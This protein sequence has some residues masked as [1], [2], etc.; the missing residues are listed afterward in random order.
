MAIATEL[1]ELSQEQR[2]AFYAQAVIA[3]ARKRLDVFGKYVFG[4]TPAAHHKKIIECITDEDKQR[5]LIVVPRSHAKTTWASI[6]YSAW[7]IGRDP[8]S[9]ILFLSNTATQAELVSVTVRKVIESE[10][11][12]RDVF[13]EVKPNPS[14]GWAR[15]GWFVHRKD[16]SAK[17]P[18]FAAS[19]VGGPVVG[20]RADLLIADDLQD[21][22]SCTTADMRDKT[23]KWFLEVAIPSVK[24]GGRILAIAT[25]WH[26]DDLMGRLIKLDWPLVHLPAIDSEGHALWPELW[27]LEKL[28]EKR[29]EI[30]TSMFQCMYQGD[31]TLM[32]AGEWFKKEWFAEYTETPPLDELT[33]VQ[34]W[35]FAARIHKKSDFTVCVTLGIDESQYEETGRFKAYVLDVWRR[36]ITPLAT[37]EAIMAQSQKWQP[38]AVGI[39]NVSYQ[40][41]Q[42]QM[43]QNNAANNNLADVRWFE[44]GVNNKPI[45]IRTQP[46]QA[47]AERGDFLL[48]TNAHWKADLLSEFVGL[49]KASHDDIVSACYV[50]LQ[51]YRK[52]VRRARPKRLVVA[53]P[54]L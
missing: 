31:P 17:D 40:V 23:A 54:W 8:E 46:L 35:D 6:I 34:G 11:K 10:P 18:T 13:P 24:P 32:E 19:G 21:S 3:Q 26:E 14:A 53:N 48:P 43:A 38:S 36:K 30:G 51:A 42:A 47:M 16:I 37:E 29:R 41:I 52:P 39:E 12:F 49:G 20:K 1:S 33:I 28:E 22:D 7:M 2:E 45:H 9:H 27:P 25:R 50:A 15:D 4:H 5:A 44:V